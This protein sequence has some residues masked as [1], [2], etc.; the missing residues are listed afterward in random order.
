MSPTSM[1][2][3]GAWVLGAAGCFQRADIESI[4]REAALSLRVLAP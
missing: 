4:A 3:D 1:V 2:A